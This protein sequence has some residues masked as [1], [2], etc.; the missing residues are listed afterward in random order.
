[1]LK[2]Y[3][4]KQTGFGFELEKSQSDYRG[5]MKRQALYK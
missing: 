4:M 5:I 2:F 1:M 3:E